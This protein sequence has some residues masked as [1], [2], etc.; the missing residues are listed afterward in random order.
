M[1][2]N[3]GHFLAKKKRLI[4]C[5]DELLRNMVKKNAVIR[6]FRPFKTPFPIVRMIVLGNSHFLTYVYL[7]FF[8][9]ALTRL[10]LELNGIGDNGAKYLADALESNTVTFILFE[11]ILHVY[12]H[13]FCID[14]HHT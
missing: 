2:R 5:Y 9:Q 10:H 3:D 14:I 11:S 1:E 7:H 12:L 6:R 8:T 13:F 4:K